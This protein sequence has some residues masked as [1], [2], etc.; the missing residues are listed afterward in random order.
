MKK[1]KNKKALKLFGL[2]VI[3]IAILVLIVAA[4]A[5]YSTS[6]ETNADISVA[7]WNIK[8]NGKS[9]SDLSSVIK[10][11]F[12][13]DDNTAANIIAPNAVGYFKLTFDFSESD[14]SCDYTIDVSSVDSTLKDLV[15]TGYSVGTNE[16]DVDNS[17]VTSIKESNVAQITGS[18]KYTDS[19]K[20]VTYKIFVKWNDDSDTAV[21]ND[22]QDTELTIGEKPETSMNVKVSFKQSSNT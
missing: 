15:I 14:V 5:R 4:Y 19:S 2:F 3:L 17:A 20:T 1:F 16:T 10:P 6:A 13:G 8:V 9:L 12:P 11:V 21:M 7:R 22:V 18:Y